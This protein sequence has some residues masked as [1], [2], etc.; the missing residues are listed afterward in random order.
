MAQAL[1]SRTVAD[2]GEKVGYAPP[3]PPI[4]PEEMAGRFPQFDILECLGRGGM[5]VVYKARQKSLNRLVA[6]KILAPERKRDARFAGRFAREAEL[7]AQLSHPHIVIIHDFGETGGLYYLV[8]EFVDGVNLR[9][10]LR[11][12]K[13]EP[14]QA[15]AI[16]PPVCEALQYAHEKGI[17]HRDIKPEN[18]LMDREGRVKIADFGIAALAG[19]PGERAGTPPYM[20]PEQVDAKPGVDHRADIY[21]LGV[22]LYEML[23]GERP[24][25]EVVAPSKKVQIDV[26]LDE[27]VLRALEKKPEL[28]YQQASVL[29]TQVETIAASSAESDA[30]DPKLEA[31]TGRKDLDSFRRSLLWYGFICGVFGLPAGLALD[32]PFVWGLSIAGIVIAGHRLRAMAITTRKASLSLG[33]PGPG[34]ATPHNSVEQQ[35][36]NEAQWN[37][38]ANWTGPKWLSLY[39]SKKDSRAW[40]PK[41]L[42]ALGWTLNL[43]HPRGATAL[44]VIVSVL[45]MLQ[46]AGSAVVLNLI[47]DH[48]ARDVS[49]SLFMPVVIGMAI[50]DGLVL[51]WLWRAVSKR[52]QSDTPWNLQPPPRPRRRWWN[53]G[54]AL[55]AVLALGGGAVVYFARQP[56]TVGTLLSSDSPDGRYA[57]WAGTEHAMRVFGDDKTFFS[58]CVQG[59]D[60][61]DR[62]E[63]PIQFD[64]L[65]TNYADRALDDYAFRGHDGTAHGQIVWSDDSQRVSFRMRGIEVSAFNVV[66]RSHSFEPGYQPCREV[67]LTGSEELRDCFLDLDT[68]Q[69]MSAPADLV[70]TLRAKGRLFNGAPQ[71]TTELQEWMQTS[72][73]DLW[74]RTGDTSL[75]HLDGVQMLM[76]EKT[77]PQADLRAF[78]TLTTNQVTKAV[79][80]VEEALKDYPAIGSPQ[81]QGNPRLFTLNAANVH[82]VKTREGAVAL[83]EILEDNPRTDR[84]RLRFKQPAL[85]RDS[86]PHAIQSA[87]ADAVQAS[88]RAAQAPFI[89]RLPQGGVELVALS[90]Y[91]STDEP[92]WAPDGSPAKEGPFVTKA[93]GDSTADFQMFAMVARLRDLP[94][95]ASKPVWKVEPRN[96]WAEGKVTS[97]SAGNTG[98]L[99]LISARFPRPAQTANV[100][101][102]IAYGPWLT[103]AST[104]ADAINPGPQSFG[105]GT[106]AFLPPT[107][108]KAGVRVSV[109][110]D[111]KDME[112]RIIAV[113]S[114]DSVQAG[115]D[116]H[117][118]IWETLGHTTM[119]FPGLSLEQA[120]Q[121]KVEF[122]FQ[123]RRYYWVEFRNVSL[124]PGFKTHVDVAQV[125]AEQVPAL[126]TDAAIKAILDYGGFV[127]T[128]A[129]GR[130]F[131]ISLVYDEEK[132][133]KAVAP[134][135]RCERSRMS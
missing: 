86:V 64:R 113:G 123:V 88:A 48:G 84:T 57:A 62:W 80:A 72:G 95:D 119:T 77:G 8:M 35:A 1:A 55:A 19:D 85:P 120:G 90:H 61:F 114:K 87:M 30:E 70:A 107:D 124:K 98:N 3:V 13:L 133:S 43:G 135:R 106:A 47:S 126:S 103:A 41:Q 74:K 91:P 52:S 51:Y 2:A 117:Q 131:R 50:M 105:Q 128:N 9:D 94:T 97:E 115:A 5:G 26:R 49:S 75:T 96:S 24:A 12:G 109:T 40:V 60:S 27:V 7:L 14:K 101:I 32:L 81:A 34:A 66:D 65:A 20:A 56:R 23:T 110:H 112:M 100:R 10:L 132:C 69:V 82:A 59:P 121:R 21:A 102:G 67:E 39:F 18:I 46:A 93:S 15:L 108:T 16:V 36:I 4:P 104:R 127:K 116:L 111:L 130:V 31:N 68:G 29:K 42:P 37:N 6:I 122:R 44:M 11:E 54:G 118:A 134:G 79:I 71:I 76:A 92:W 99:A 53:I 63:T 73:A 125:S 38:P 129:Q 25:K 45:V 22:V 17:V 78:D 83:V 58:F 89:A 33:Q 28:R